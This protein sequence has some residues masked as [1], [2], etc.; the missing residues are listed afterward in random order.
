MVKIRSRGAVILLAVLALVSA[1]GDIKAKDNA[2]KYSVFSDPTIIGSTVYSI[3][4]YYPNMAKC[5]TGLGGLVADIMAHY[6]SADFAVI[7]AG[8]VRWTPNVDPS[9]SYLYAGIVTKGDVNRFLPFDNRTGAGSATNPS[10]VVLASMTGS[11]IK[12]MFEN[13]FTRMQSDGTPGTSYG[14]FL[15]TS[16]QLRVYA[17]VRQPVG[18]RITRIVFN[19]SDINLADTAITYRVAVPLKY[20]NNAPGYVNFDQYWSITAQGTNIVDTKK[21]IYDLVVKAFM[22]HSPILAADLQCGDPTYGRLMITHN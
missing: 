17:D 15:Q 11:V 7:N 18:S 13:S 12:Q 1:C 19:G 16:S 21:Y 2:E 10:T 5:D 8:S 6:A 20:I 4:T 9:V 3:T 14:R 22:E